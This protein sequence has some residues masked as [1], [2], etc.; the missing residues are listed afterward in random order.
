MRFRMRHHRPE[1]APAAP[2]AIAERPAPEWL[3]AEASAPE[4]AA[5]APAVAVP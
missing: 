5:A 2:V 3:P 4:P 1:A